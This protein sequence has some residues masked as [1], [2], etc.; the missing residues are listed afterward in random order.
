[1]KQS[2]TSYKDRSKA[3]RMRGYRI[4]VMYMSWKTINSYTTSF[5]PPMDDWHMVI[6]TP[7]VRCAY[8]VQSGR[9][10]ATFDR[11]D[12]EVRGSSPLNSPSFSLMR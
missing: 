9:K 6:N 5:T 10:I 7:T 4:H 12:Y 2:I 3:P 11:E 1:M 8:L